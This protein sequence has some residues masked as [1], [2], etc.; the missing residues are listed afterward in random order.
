MAKEQNQKID[1]KWADKEM[2]YASPSKWKNKIGKSYQGR[3]EMSNK[4]AWRESKY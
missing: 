1:E 3:I 4:E 2:E